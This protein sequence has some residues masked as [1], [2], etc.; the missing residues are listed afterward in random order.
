M[1]KLFFNILTVGLSFVSFS[2]SAIGS[3]ETFHCGVGAIVAKEPL[4][5]FTETINAG[6]FDSKRIIYADRSSLIPECQTC[7]CADYESFYWIDSSATPSPAIFVCI[8]VKAI[9]EEYF[10][11]FS[12]NDS[13]EIRLY[14]FPGVY[15]FNR[16][17]WLIGKVEFVERIDPI[18]N[19]IR[20]SFS[21]DQWEYSQGDE[22]DSINAF[23]RYRVLESYELDSEWWICVADTR[24]WK[25]SLVLGSVYVVPWR[26]EEFLKV[27]LIFKAG[28]FHL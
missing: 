21:P 2:Q 13:C 6:K 17:E 1:K 5:N 8:P 23:N 4:I 12:S 15:N 28:A 9:E 3:A 20:E 7:N 19:P 14:K 16:W 24:Y 27:K 10:I 26:D 11:L 18:N 22:Y 25:D